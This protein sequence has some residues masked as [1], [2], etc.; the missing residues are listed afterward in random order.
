[1]NGQLIWFAAALDR[2]T[3]NNTEYI[4][5]SATRMTANSTIH[6]WNLTINAST[7]FPS[8]STPNAPPF[9]GVS[10]LYVML[11]TLFFSLIIVAG[12]FGNALI[13]AT[14][15]R[16]REMRTP[17]SLL[18]ANICAAD[19]GVCVLA[20]PL[21]IIEIYH[22]WPFGD[23]LCQIFFPLQDVFVCVSVVT[24]TVIALERHRAIVSPFKPTLTLRRV[25][26]V[27]PAVWVACYVTAGVPMLLFIT[28][29]LFPDGKFY[30][31]PVFSNKGYRIAYEMYLVIL[32]ITLPLVVQSLAYF[33]IIRL[34]R[35]KDE[36]EARSESF[37]P[38]SSMKKTINDRLRQKKHL[39]RILVVLMLAFQICYLPRGVIMLLTEFSPETTS[40]PDFNYVN[41]ITLAMYYIKHVI[42][43]VILLAMSK[44]FRSGCL[45][46]C[47]SGGKQLP[48]MRGSRYSRSRQATMRSSARTLTGV[49]M[50]MISGAGDN[51]SDH[52]TNNMH[53]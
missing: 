29:T 25:S 18:I 24:Q 15:S 36:I 3:Q 16:W 48:F 10:Q 35:A 27:V 30:C 13:V 26:M 8:N 41:L 37:L 7:R 49:P 2:K 45:N 1:M 46:I 42:N 33:D 5:R 51:I 32:F 34:L 12:L 40:K 44:D 43:P 39:V 52:L 22:G 38:N 50:R 28:V 17:C 9:A 6:M 31:F 53:R 11:R 20:A 19:L 47:S 14:L 21:R 23:V 4:G